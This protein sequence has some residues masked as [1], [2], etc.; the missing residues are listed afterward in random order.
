MCVCVC[1]FVCV[2]VCVCVCV[3]PLDDGSAFG[4]MF[5]LQRADSHAHM[6]AQQLLSHF[7]S[8]QYSP[9][10]A[11]ARAPRGGIAHGI[12]RQGVVLTDL[13]SLIDC[14]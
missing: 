6:S 5:R 7:L 9:S 11:G 10:Y 1:V 14:P 12:A 3:S 13:Q 2:C 8:L 4:T